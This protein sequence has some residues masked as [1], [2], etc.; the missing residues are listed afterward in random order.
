MPMLDPDT[1]TDWDVDPPM[2][3]HDGEFPTWMTRPMYACGYIDQ[4]DGC[5]THPLNLTPECHQGVTCPVLELRTPA[6]STAV[7]SRDD[8]WKG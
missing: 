5:C 3:G 2:L 1:I 8:T 6:S 7:P 4:N